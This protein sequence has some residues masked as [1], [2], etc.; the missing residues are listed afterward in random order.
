[1]SAVF[2]TKSRCGDIQCIVARDSK[3]ASTVHLLAHD[4]MGGVH[5]IVQDKYH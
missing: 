2:N 3:C 1:M 4:G 5:G